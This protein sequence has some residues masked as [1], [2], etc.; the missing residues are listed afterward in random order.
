MNKKPAIMALLNIGCVAMHQPDALHNTLKAGNATECRAILTHLELT[1]QSQNIQD[2]DG[3]TP[4]MIGIRELTES[5]HNTE[6]SA[7]AIK[8]HARRYGHLYICAGYLALCS[9]NIVRALRATPLDQKPW[10][11]F[12]AACPIAALFLVK[13]YIKGFFGWIAE[14]ILN[15]RKRREII[16]RQALC[17]MLL[18]APN[19]LIDAKSTNNR[20]KSC[21]Q[22]LDDAIA[23]YDTYGTGKHINSMRAHHRTMLTTLQDALRK[24]ATPLPEP[25]QE[26]T[27]VHPDF[28]LRDTSIP[29]KPQVPVA[30][31]EPDQPLTHYSYPDLFLPYQNRAK[32]TQS[33]LGQIRSAEPLYPDLSEVNGIN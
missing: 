12:K 10:V 8:N 5:M 13:R 7:Q 22:V 18:N 21:L 25:A 24:K 29:E 27:D 3:N 16:N 30:Q 2:N 19:N 9:R 26:H 4:I 1:G 6:R 20:G 23:R 17:T 15:L 32:E 31:P 28:D 11:A 14:K 33:R